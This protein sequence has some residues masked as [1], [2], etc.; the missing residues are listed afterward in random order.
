MHLQMDSSCLRCHYPSETVDHLFWDCTIASSLW[1]KILEWWGFILQDI[2]PNTK[3]LKGILALA[4][5]SNL[6][7]AWEIVVS[8][9][10]WTLWLARNE[11]IFKGTEIS[12]ENSLLLVQLRSFQWCL[13]AEL[14]K[15]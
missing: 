10:F 13:A 5:G 2:Q 9:T 14:I 3:S 11:H 7:Q 15:S 4:R 1:P 12:L 8:S 6:R